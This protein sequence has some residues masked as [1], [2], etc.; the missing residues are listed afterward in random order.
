[1]SVVG[2]SPAQAV[3]V[4]EPASGGT[5]V[6]G[7]DPA[8]TDALAAR[9]SAGRPAAGLSAD[10]LAALGPVADAAPVR[11]AADGGFTLPTGD[12]LAA[13]RVRWASATAAFDGDDV[14]VALTLAGPD[15]PTLL[16]FVNLELATKLQAA[17]PAMKPLCDRLAAADPSARRTDAGLEM[18]FPVRVPLAELL[19]VVEQLVPAGE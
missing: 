17:V 16:D 9:Q 15:R 2:G 1:M 10:L 5:V 6:I 14:V 11:F 18:T 19:A 7:T 12:T 3:A 8:V 13:H 4:G